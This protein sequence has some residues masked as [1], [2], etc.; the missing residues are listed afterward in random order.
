MPVRGMIE[1]SSSSTLVMT[2]R[3]VPT[4]L[5][6]EDVDAL[7]LLAISMH[8]S[9]M[10]P[11]LTVPVTRQ[12]WEQSIMWEGKSELSQQPLWRPAGVPVPA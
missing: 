6:D 2:S 3:T 8:Q 9:L 10:P 5:D 4:V 1:G 11:L 12:Q 7:T